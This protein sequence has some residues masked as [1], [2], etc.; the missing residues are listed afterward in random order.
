MESGD[1]H[2]KTDYLKNK[3]IIRTGHPEISR[4]A[5]FRTPSLK[6]L[7]T[8]ETHHGM[9]GPDGTSQT[10]TTAMTASSRRTFPN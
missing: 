1:F 5:R 3:V 2:K 10:A 6:A 4:P 9:D 8:P 7:E